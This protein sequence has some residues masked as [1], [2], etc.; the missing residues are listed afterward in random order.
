[1]GLERVLLA[2]GDEGLEPPAGATLH[3]FVVAVG[4]GHD[5]APS[6]LAAVRDAGFAAEAALEDRPMGAQMRQADRAGARVAVVLGD[7]EAQAGTVT[8]RR[9]A[10]GTQSEGTI[11]D[12]IAWLTTEGS[13]A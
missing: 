2:L 3:V 13:S 5:V 12:V 11:E 4:A 8:W 6:V 7:R 9:L 1:M 10:D